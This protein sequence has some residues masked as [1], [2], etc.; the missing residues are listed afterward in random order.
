MS[1]NKVTLSQ[2]ADS[3][4]LTATVQSQEVTATESTETSTVAQVVAEVKPVK[5][6]RKGIKGRP[7]DTTGATTMGKAREIYA[8]NP[9]FTNVQLRDAVIAATGCKKPVAATYA[10]K[11]RSAAKP[12]VTPVAA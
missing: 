10:S 1:E 7:L 12:T 5:A 6:I 2:L 9:T 3:Q 4:E 8:A 11:V